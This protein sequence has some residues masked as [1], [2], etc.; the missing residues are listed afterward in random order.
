MY[1]DGLPVGAV[2]ESK[3]FQG[4]IRRPSGLSRNS[5]VAIYQ[6]DSRVGDVGAESREC[7]YNRLES[8]E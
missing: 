4:G 5:L 6:Q 8:D 3:R 2:H 1:V 7:I